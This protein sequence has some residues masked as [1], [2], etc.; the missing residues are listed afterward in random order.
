METKL[1][2]L[3]LDDELPG[4]TYLRMLCEKLPQ[5]EVVKAFNSP[6]RFLE[7]YQQLDFDFSIVDI[8]MPGFSGLEVAQLLKEKPVIICTAY[9]EY[10]AE[11]FEL[12]AIDYI[13]KPIR[14]ERLLRAIEKVSR[15]LKPL[16]TSK[17]FVQLNTNK[18]KALIFFERL[19]RI[20]SSEQDKRDKIA[21]LNNGEVVVLK[22]VSFDYLL[23]VLPSKD[24]CRISKKDIIALKA[25]QFFN[26][27]EVTLTLKDHNQVSV[28][29]NIGDSY[30]HHFIALLQA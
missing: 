15:Y 2:C 21:F 30:R 27:D 3:L 12:E 10:A 11:A 29:L 19:Q 4:L 6:E 28:V 25:V 23:S 16:Q 14:Q 13:V 24:F 8:E 20:T 1:K 18:G 17:D 22:N 9:K 26:F 7:E 5:V